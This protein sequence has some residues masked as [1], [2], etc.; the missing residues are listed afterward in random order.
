MK[1]CTA[2]FSFIILFAAC[3]TVQNKIIIIPDPTEDKLLEQTGR[4]EHWQIIETQNGPT[5]N[6][7]PEWVRRYLER[8]TKG[9]ESLEAYSDKYVFVGENWG[10]NFNVLQQWARGFAVAQDLPRL[11]AYRAERRLVAAAVYYPDDEYGEYF[12]KLIKKMSD[13]EYPGASKEQTFWLKVKV[14]VVGEGAIDDGL[15]QEDAFTE[16]Y[17]FLT[18][19]SIDKETLQRQIRGIMADVTTKT[20]PTRGQSQAINRIQQ[21]FFEDF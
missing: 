13:G 20:P 2:L 7:I 17:E 9:V 8:G 6:G 4:I 10:E 12:E 1:R 5:E 15:P 16:R 11:I 14:K 18:L 21:N 19:I 3:T